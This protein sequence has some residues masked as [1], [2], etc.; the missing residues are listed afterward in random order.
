MTTKVLGYTLYLLYYG[1]TTHSE[2]EST[3][4]EQRA[5]MR[6]FHPSLTGL[7]Q[8]HVVYRYSRYM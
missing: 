8:L 7:A 3:A 4:T 5:C 6:L 2:P 1:V